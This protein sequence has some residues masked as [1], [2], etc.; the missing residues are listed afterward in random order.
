MM[1]GT[2]AFVSQVAWSLRVP[3]SSTLTNVPPASAIAQSSTSPPV[4]ASP[5][6]A[7]FSVN[8]VAVANV[9]FGSTSAVV[10]EPPPPPPPPPPTPPQAARRAAGNRA[11]RIRERV[12]GAGRI[13]D[14]LAGWVR[15][16]H[17]REC[18]SARR[19]PEQLPASRDG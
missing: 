13:L 15:S 14:F 17:A 5:V 10:A 18:W 4:V 2:L 6:P 1:F 3:K 9:S 7:V 8:G 11:A 12:R 16:G 19:S